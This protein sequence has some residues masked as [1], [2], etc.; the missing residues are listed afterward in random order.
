MVRQHYWLSLNKLQE[1]EGQGSVECCSPWGHR[2]LD[3]T[4]GLNNIGLFS[5]S[6]S[7]FAHQHLTGPEVSKGQILKVAYLLTLKRYPPMTGETMS[8]PLWPIPSQWMKSE[9][10]HNVGNPE[11]VLQWEINQI[12]PTYAKATWFRGGNDDF[13]IRDKWHFYI[14]TNQS[15]WRLDKYLT[16]SKLGGTWYSFRWGLLRCP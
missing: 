5:Q 8:V 2:E 13:I 11:I 14:N 1:T 7:S 12:T 9:M 15:C 3:T 16:P 6:L 10:W 4:E